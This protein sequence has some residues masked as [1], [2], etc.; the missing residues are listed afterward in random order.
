M[1]I[2]HSAGELASFY[3]SSAI[4]LRDCLEFSYYRS[5]YQNETVNMGNMIVINKNFD[6]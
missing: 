3:A 2:G 5:M 6:F 4:T 1:V